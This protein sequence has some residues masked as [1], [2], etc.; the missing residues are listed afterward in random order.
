MTPTILSSVLLFIKILTIIGLFVYIA[1]AAIIVRQEQL[2]NGVFEEGFEQ[3]LKLLVFIHL[4]AS[5][6]VMFFAFVLL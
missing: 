1:F 3:V 2:M 5:V 4:A 6:G